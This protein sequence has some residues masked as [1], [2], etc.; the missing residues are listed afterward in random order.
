V[1]KKLIQNKSG[2]LGFILIFILL[3]VAAFAPIIAPYSPVK[4]NFSI[5]FQK[6]SAAHIMGTDSYGRDILSRVIFGTRVSLKV[7]VGA[8]GVALLVGSILGLVAGF[9][10]GW[11]DSLIQWMAEVCW[12][13]PTVLYALVL[14]V[15]IGP[16]LWTA[17]IAIGLSYW[18]R[19]ER[20]MRSEVLVNREQGYV[21]A[22]R[23][24]GASNIGI[25][26]RHI[27]PNSMASTVV[28]STLLMGQAIGEE[29]TLSF[30][31]IG[32]QPPTPSW[33]LML[34]EARTFII[35]APWVT[36]F[37]GV[38]IVLVVIGFS[39][40]GDALRDVLDPRLKGVGL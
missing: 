32:T 19:F 12:A 39:L 13:F 20:L 2:L 36:I 27:L 4:Q 14:T 31:G 11:I 6:P 35:S 28:V 18:P 23:A 16:G 37:P 1:F 7:A 40:L 24:L 33:G 15:L 3:L 21:E 10:G 22:A 38:A 5:A 26:F 9:F 8:T 17:L 34:A 30:L 25:I 29:A